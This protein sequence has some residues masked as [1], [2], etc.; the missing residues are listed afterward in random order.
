MVVTDVRIAI[1]MSIPL[2]SQASDEPPDHVQGLSKTLFLGRIGY[3]P[4]SYQSGFCCNGHH[5]RNLFVV[6][7]L[8]GPDMEF[9]SGI[10]LYRRCK[11]GRQLIHCHGFAIPV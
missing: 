8:V 11:T 9:H 3:E 6:N 4:D 5:L 1:C 10:L 2:P 7:V